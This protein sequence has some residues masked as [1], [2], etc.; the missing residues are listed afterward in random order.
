MTSEGRRRR[1]ARTWIAVG[2]GLVIGFVA[3]FAGTIAW[4]LFGRRADDA[5]PRGREVA[6]QVDLF[7]LPSRARQEMFLV[8]AG[9]DAN[10]EPRL[11]TALFPDEDPPR[12]LALLLLANVSPDE[13]WHVDL[14]AAPLACRTSAGSA[15]T[16][17]QKLDPTG[18]ARL[19]PS[20]RLRLR[21][22]SAAGGKLTVEPRSM[23]RVLLALPPKCRL[24]DLSDVQWGETPLVRDQ[25]DLE[26]IRR[27][28]EDPAAVTTGR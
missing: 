6:Q 12:E 27:F 4:N 7:R 28:R 26:R 14:D 21:S 16:P 20:D 17:L 23:L 25:L 13:P 22:L 3:A 24:A 10:G 18:A 5:P 2:G 19:A 11:A 8:P 1:R 15:L 9:P